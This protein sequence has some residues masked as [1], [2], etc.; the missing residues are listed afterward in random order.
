MNSLFD[1]NDAEDVG[2]QVA[3]SAFSSIADYMVDT[4]SVITVLSITVPAE[5]G[6]LVMVYMARDKLVEALRSGDGNAWIYASIGVFV[7]GFLIAFAVFRLLPRSFP[8]P[9]FGYTIW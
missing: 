4:Q 1:N 9:F 3:T 8:K 5:I 7:V 6:C 2:A